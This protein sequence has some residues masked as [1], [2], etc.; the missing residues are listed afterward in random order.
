MKNPRKKKREKDLRTSK[1]Q[2]KYKEW[3]TTS[4]LFTSKNEKYNINYLDRTKQV[5]RGVEQSGS[6]SG[7]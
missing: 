3:E 7:S 2:K 6:S 1:D 5:Y 4:N